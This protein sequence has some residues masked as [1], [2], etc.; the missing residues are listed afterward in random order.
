MNGAAI[1]LVRSVVVAAVAVTIAAPALAQQS[2]NWKWCVNQGG[3]FS[4]DVQIEGCTGVIRSGRESKSNLSIANY[5]RG[6]GYYAKLDYDR[7]IADYSEAIRLN[8]K[9]PSAFNNRGNAYKAKGDLDRALADYNE[10]I[11][12]DRKHANA[13]GNRANVYKARG[14]LDRALTDYDAALRIRPGAN[15]YNNRGNTYFDKKDYDRAIADYSDALRTDPKYTNALF[16][17]GRAYYAKKDYARAIADYS[18]VL[19]ID[20]K[21][22]SAL[23][24]RGNSY[25]ARQ[26]YDRALADYSEVIRF[27]PKH[28]NAYSNRGD[29]YRAKGDLERA[30]M[31]YDAALR[32]RPSTADYNSRGNTYYDKKDYDRAIADYSEAIRIDPKYVIAYGNRGNIYRTKGDIDR[33][34]AD[35]GEAIRLEPGYTA[36]FTNRGMAHEKKGDVERARADFNAALALPPKFSSGAWAHETARKR[37]AALAAPKASPSVA[38][39]PAATS[40]AAVP[41][42]AA[43]PV[44]PSLSVDRG[45]RVALVI[46]NGTYVNVTPLPNPPNDARDLAGVLRGLGFRVIEGYDLDVMAMRRMI[47]EF[48]DA[49]AG[50]RVTLFFYAGHG[51]Q[52]AGKNYLVPID[53]KLDRP[54]ALGLEAIEISA[55]LADMEAEKRTNLVF[56]DACRDNPLSRSLARSLGATRSA[57]VGQGLAQLNA[58]IGTLIAFATGPDTVALDGRGRNSPFTAALLKHIGTPGL[59]VRSMLTRVRADVINATNEKQVPWDHSSLTGEFYFRGGS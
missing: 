19:R 58:G 28:A 30:L 20:P 52:V 17:R 49:M 23:F 44:A 15:D 1:W 54:S 5:N 24:N 32:L 31:D 2:K 8:S 38:T 57:S 18:E 34:L 36:A 40:T 6:N 59:E 42:Q 51:L 50:A 41:P 21:Y 9:Y 29:A 56:L 7:A 22:T 55:V 10:A 33:A 11:R 26:D 53:A 25:Y 45:P 46:G 13:Y 37:L 39:A 48:G 16:N 43:S 3:S 14:D 47:A 35:Y 12:L 4:H 27:D